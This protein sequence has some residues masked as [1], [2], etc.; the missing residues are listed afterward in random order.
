M[1]ERIRKDL[2]IEGPLSPEM[3]LIGQRILDTALASSKAKTTL[4]L[5]P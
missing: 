5:V 1:V 3:A 2:P 4:A